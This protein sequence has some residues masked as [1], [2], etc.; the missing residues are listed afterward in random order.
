MN[1]RMCD[2]EGM[3]Q[4]KMR[5][6]SVRSLSLFYMS[7]LKVAT[8]SVD[9]LGSVPVSLRLSDYSRHHHLEHSHLEVG[10]HAEYQRTYAASDL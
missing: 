2:Y 8:R 6:D 7:I 3:T 9:R 4:C 10:C 1:S 5:C